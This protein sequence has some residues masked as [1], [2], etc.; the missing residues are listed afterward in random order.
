MTSIGRSR[1][2]G[3]AVVASCARPR[4]GVEPGRDDGKDAA[5]SEDIRLLGRLLGDVVRDQ[6]GDE[7]FELVEAVRQRAVDARRDG[8]QPAR[9]AGRDAPRAARSTTSCTSSGPSAGCRCSPT[10]PRTCTTSAAAATTAPTARGPQVGSVAATLDHLVAAGV[11]G[12]RDRAPSSTS[13]SSS[14]VITA[15]PTEVR[16][17]TVLDII[18]EVARRARRPAPT[19]AGH[20]RPRPSSTTASACSCSRCGRRPCCACP[21]CASPTRSTRRCAT[22]ARACSSVV[23]ALERDLERLVA[24]RWSVDVD[25]TRA[26][27]DGLVDRRRPRR[28]PVRDRRRAALGHRRAGRSPR[29]TT[30][31][32]SCAGCPASCRCRTAS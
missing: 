22:T 5:L 13:C 10:R 30:T 26:V 6:A 20:A 19:P 31:S 16:R 8:A 4:R 32:A 3:R 24:E 25:A 1:A 9:R 17:Q 7:V 15:H 14:P 12:R 28:Q 2:R 29:S 21:S 23:P 18:G 27:R 11:D